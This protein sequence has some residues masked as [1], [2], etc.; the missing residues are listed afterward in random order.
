M[1]ELKVNKISPRSGTAI[2][3][4]DSGD[5]F[6]IP[7]GATLAIAGSVTGFT[8]AGIDDNATSVAITINSS[9]QVG[10]GTTSPD[11]LLHISASSSNAQLKLQRTG[12]ATASYNISASS[13]SLAFSNQVAGAEVMRVNSTGLGIGTST[14]ANTL[15]VNSSAGA[16][17]KITRDSQSS[18]LQLSTD[19]SSGQ[20][21]SGA[22]A[23]KF[24]TGSSEV[25]RF[26]TSG[27]FGIG[28]SSPTAPLHIDTNTADANNPFV[29]F[30]NNDGNIGQIRMTSSGDFGFRANTG[31]TGQMFF[32]V[33]G[34]TEAM[35]ILADGKVSIGTIVANQKL[36]IFDSSSSQMNFYTSGTG[37]TNGDGFRVGFNGS[38]GQLYLFEDADFRIATNNSEKFRIKSDGK[39]GIGTTSPTEV[40]H[41]VGDIL[42]TGG[43]F[44]SDANNYLG[45]SNDTFARFVVN[46]TE[47]FRVLSSGRVGIGTTNPN[48][49]LQVEDT[50]SNIPQIR[51][52]TNDGGNKRLDLFV[53]NGIGTVSAAQSA[54]RLAFKTAGGEAVR[55]DATGNVGIGT[56]LPNVDL[57]VVASNGGNVEE[58]L[59][60]RNN[61]TSNGT[62]SR[63]R[64]TN[65]TVAGTTG[66]SVSISSL[67]NSDG[68][69][70]LLFETVGSE[71][72]RINSSGNILIGTTSP[73]RLDRE[74]LEIKNTTG[75]A[76][77]SAT[78]DLSYAGRVHRSLQSGSGTH[79]IDFY[80]TSSNTNVGA[81]THN[82]SSTSFVTSS[83]Y[84]LKENVV[85]ITDATSRL[86]QLK[87]KRF[88]FIADADTTV[89]GFLA[90]EV[91]NI[92]PEAITG[93][94]DE[95]D[96]DG[97][98]VYQG[99]DQ[100]KLVPLL[101]KTIQELEARITTLEANNP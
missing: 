40:L 81:I 33:G 9:E 47:V 34:S 49:N 43:D 83:D 71:R 38:V 101:V 15:D 64:F 11:H 60:L 70:D 46:D 25:G 27:N 58:I 48:E 96:V 20:V 21:F 62:G 39:V 22:G 87:P 84:R 37:T 32:Q 41:V 91:S 74:K 13:D 19:G 42:A 35:R 97:N 94:K 2:T 86:K 90:H 88:N 54:Q 29:N 59:E 52:Q 36:N 24:K 50:T 61:S 89:D 26:D 79:F 44:K 14:I 73:Q 28:T 68:N 65:S 100:S 7:S 1:S 57:N 12:S 16:V 76:I 63:L 75:E 30:D 4:G 8:S 78:N 93:T 17:I 23:L 67:R 18:Y 31:G 98:P 3:L 80:T 99:I 45:F 77:F 6:T 66:N 53:D 95:V 5:T 85:E 82:D 72:M 51:I 55:I 69:Q 56:S 10:I 92:V